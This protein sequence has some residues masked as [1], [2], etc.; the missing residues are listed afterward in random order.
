[1][2]R[3]GDHRNVLEIEESEMNKSPMKRQW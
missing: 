2:Y 3:S 1:M